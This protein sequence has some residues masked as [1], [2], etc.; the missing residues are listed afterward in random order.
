MAALRESAFSSQRGS[1]S[2]TSSI[3]DP[4]KSTAEFS[5]ASPAASAVSSS[6]GILPQFQQLQ[7]QNNDIKAW[8]QIEGTKVNY[9]VMQT[10][11]EP[12]FYLHRNLHKE[13]ESRGLPFLDAESDLEKSKNYLVYGHNMR[14]GT[15]FAGLLG[16]LDQSF[17]EKHRMIRFDTQY[18]AGNY[19]V[20]AVFRS[21]IYTTDSKKFKYYQYEN[22]ETQD[23]FNTYINHV[24]KLE[25][26]ETGVGASYGD[27]LLTLS[28]CYEYV[29]DGRLVIVA[30]KVK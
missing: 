25:D 21:R 3:T 15:A 29:K 2:G 4:P 23:D 26:Y 27:Q 16:Y 19:Q 22:I 7:A 17:F 30:K 24:K 14:D 20:I 12:E 8:I 10:P 1:F 5:E 13:E 28:T 18:G 6:R 11:E 9:P